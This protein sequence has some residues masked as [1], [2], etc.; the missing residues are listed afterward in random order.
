LPL[1]TAAIDLA[2]ADPVPQRADG[3]ESAGSPEAA[4]ADD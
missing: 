4:Q 1:E 3:D 2:K